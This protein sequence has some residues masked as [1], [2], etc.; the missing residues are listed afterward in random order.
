MLAGG[1]FG[2]IGF[3]LAVLGAFAVVMIALSVLSM[4]RQAYTA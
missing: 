3:E 2:E 1:G 4:R